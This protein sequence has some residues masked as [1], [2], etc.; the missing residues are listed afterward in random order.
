ML[1]SIVLY[2]FN[3]DIVSNSIAYKL[4]LILHI[5]MKFI[6]TLQLEKT[7]PLVWGRKLTLRMELL[8]TYHLDN[9]RG[10]LLH[11]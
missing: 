5:Y 10:M 4:S 3:M 11:I 6:L 7:L 8:Y 1:Y 2:I 9:R